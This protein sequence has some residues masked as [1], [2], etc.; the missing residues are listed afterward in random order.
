MISNIKINTATTLT[1]LSVVIAQPK[2]KVEFEYYTVNDGL[3]E[4]SVDVILQDKK[5]FIWAGTE[6]GLC[7]FDG[8][9]FKVFEHNPFDSTTLMGNAI[10]SLFQDR[11]NRLW[12]GTGPGL[13][14]Y[15][16]TTETFIRYP[17]KL[18]NKNSIPQFPN[19]IEEDNQGN[20]WCVGWTPGIYKLDPE[21]GAVIVFNYDPEDDTSILANPKSGTNMFKKDS[22]GNMWSHHG[23]G[24]NLIDPNTHKITRI[25]R[26]KNGGSISSDTIT[27]FLPDKFGNLWIGTNK[28]LDRMDI[29]TKTFEYYRHDT[30]DKFSISSDSINAISGNKDGDLWVST[31]NGLN[32]FIQQDQIF[33]QYHHDKNDPN[34]L[35]TKNVGFSVQ[36][37]RFPYVWYFPE[38]EKPGISRLNLN[39]GVSQNFAFDP[40]NPKSINDFDIRFIH[41]DKFGTMWF[42]TGSGGLNKLDPAHEKF[43]GFQQDPNDPY[44]IPGQLAIDM[45]A[46]NNGDI[47]VSTENGIAIYKP[48][49]HT[50]IKLDLKKHIKKMAF[51]NRAYIDSKERLW[52]LVNPV[53]VFD[54]KTNKVEKTYKPDV[55]RKSKTSLPHWNTWGLLEDSRGDMWFAHYVGLSKL[56]SDGETFT[57]YIN[58]PNDPKSI[59][60]G[61]MRVL[62][63]D[64][65]NR[66]WVGTH[67]AG[68]LLWERDTGTYTQYQYNPK[69]KT[70]IGAN[71]I[72]TIN[73]DRQG[74]LWIGTWGGGLNL[75]NPETETFSH[76]FKEHGLPSNVIS[77]IIP[78]NAGNLWLSTKNG[79]S[80]FNTADGVFKNFDKDDGLHGS[81]FYTDTY[82]VNNRGYMYF[83]GSTGMTEVIPGNIRENTNIP[84]VAITDMKK[85]NRDGEQTNMDVTASELKL[86]YWEPSFRAEFVAL[87]FTKSEKNQ[88]AYMLKG[89]DKDW[90]HAGSYRFANYTNL[91]PGGYTFR[92]KGSNNDGLW[93]EEGVSMAVT[94]FPAPWQTWWAYSIYVIILGLSVYTYVRRQKHIHSLEI[95]ENRKSE[96]LDLARQFQEDMLPKKMPDT[97]NFDIAAVIK[98]ST[99]VGGDYYDFFQQDDGSIYVVTGDATGHGMTAGMM[100]S[101]T[102]AGLY[103]IPAIPTDQITNRLNRVIKN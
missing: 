21:T 101:I 61:L 38:K 84:T 76:Y 37:K 99:E 26:S 102:K 33:I 17:H 44:S 79:L 22:L 56:N 23:K 89:F 47:Y 3:A 49:S 93:N 25:L 20:I 62:F 36:S 74:R 5:G 100:V 67:N 73:E 63:E 66:F 55:K 10:V 34:S 87:N 30:N 57:N 65:Q 90:V 1:L 19:S 39:T 53:I 6:N 48:K 9:A 54:L 68:L 43:T 70:G 32:R 92:V 94:V 35:T 42:G 103:G 86:S 40:T 60:R 18:E 45:K 91:P 52:Y 82:A 4:N 71:T 58:D 88:Y 2:Q 64:S 77:G 24:L 95:E 72:T 27:T 12:V 8:Y 96:E 15:N 78:D 98:T 51:I 14:L 7:R 75:F 28:G 83:G 29:R 41:E 80:F 59:P 16:P 13:N 69:D 85:V 31:K 46:R 97:P 11:K 50:F 81:E